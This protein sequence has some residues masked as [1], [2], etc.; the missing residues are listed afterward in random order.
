MGER[1]NRGIVVPGLEGARVLIVEDERHVAGSIR[2]LLSRAGAFVT[3]ASTTSAARSSLSGDLVWDLVLLDQHLP[4]GDGIE[5]LDLIDR[6]VQRPALIAV[7]GHLQVAMRSLRLQSRGAILL[8]KPFVRDELLLAAADAIAAAARADGTRT[9]EPES[10]VAEAALSLAFGPIVVDLVTQEVAVDGTV[11]DVQ[12]AQFRIL[13]QL[14]ANQG[15][16]LS[17][18]ELVGGA[19]PSRGDPTAGIRFQIHAL[20]RRLGDAGKCIETSSHGYGIG[21][22]ADEDADA[23][24]R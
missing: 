1:E 22:S 6:L 15:R 13:V 10:G 16:A 9:T 21:L 19:F 5:L 8:P 3:V 18:S 14:L 11:V 23:P 12:P 24:D 2:R 20:R 17:A 4:D 7:S